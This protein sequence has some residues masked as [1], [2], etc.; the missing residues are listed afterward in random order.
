M[1]HFR[2]SD[3]TI[4]FDLYDPRFNSRKKLVFKWLTTTSW[5][6]DVTI[7]LSDF[8][9]Q[10]YEFLL[11]LLQDGPKVKLPASYGFEDYGRVIGLART[12]RWET[13]VLFDDLEKVLGYDL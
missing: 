2:F 9:A 5:A 7:D 4:E 3:K 10:D 11:N 6:G 13:D 8:H 12:L 1:V